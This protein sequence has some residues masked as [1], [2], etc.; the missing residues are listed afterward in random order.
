[1][2]ITGQVGPSVN[3]DGVATEPVRQTR[4]GELAVTEVHGR[5]YEQSRR[6]NLFLARAIVTAPVIFTTNTG[7][8]GPFLWNNTSTVVANII[9]VSMG[10]ITTASGVAASLGLTGGTGQTAV[11]GSTS[12][13]DSSANTYIGGAAA[14]CTTYKIGTPT[15]AGS[16][17][18]PLYGVDTGATSIAHTS[19]WIELYSAITVPQ[20]G[21]VSLA[22]SATMTSAV[23]QLGMM[24][25][26]VAV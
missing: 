23:M 19:G 5:Y 1:M 20:Y 4:T 12:A 21:W 15:V 9:A 14:A 24:W 16:W 10:G 17:F 2:Q 26:E 3:S 18:L 7:T 25:E 11:P 8:G 13:I 22:A 6:G